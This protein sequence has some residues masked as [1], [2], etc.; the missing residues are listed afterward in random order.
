M[1][2]RPAGIFNHTCLTD[3]CTAPLEREAFQC[4]GVLKSREKPELL[5]IILEFTGCRNDRI[6]GKN[7][8]KSSIAIR[9]PPPHPF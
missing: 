5:G 2:L 9:L 8:A 6:N 7:T 4:S 1:T 3:T